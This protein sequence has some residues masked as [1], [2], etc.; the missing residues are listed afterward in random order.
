VEVRPDVSKCRAVSDALDDY[1]MM[2]WYP[3]KAT[4]AAA[5]PCGFPMFDS[6]DEQIRRDEIRISSDQQRGIRWAL[7]SLAGLVIVGGLIL[8]ATLFR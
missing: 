4:K 7:Y 3:T 2:L 6:L 5:T 8:S 1:P